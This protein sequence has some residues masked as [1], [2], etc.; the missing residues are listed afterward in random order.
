MIQF[1]LGFLL[2]TT[3]DKI[4]VLLDDGFNPI[5]LVG[6]L[7]RLCQCIHEMF[8]GINKVYL[9]CILGLILFILMNMSLGNIRFKVRDVDQSRNT[10]N[11]QEKKKKEG[12]AKPVLDRV[13]QEL[14]HS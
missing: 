5:L 12:R 2:T 1:T 7:V 10:V 6:N 3:F 4:E 13:K 9:E 11:T 8:L 14:E